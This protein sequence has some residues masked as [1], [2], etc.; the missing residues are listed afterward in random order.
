[1]PNRTAKFVAAIFLLPAAGP[2]ATTSA[3]AD[4]LSE[5]KDQTPAGSHWRYR[6]EHPS[7]R[8]CW[9]LRREGEKPAQLATRPAPAKAEPPMQESVA[10]ARAELTPPTRSV[11]EMDVGAR[12]VVAPGPANVASPAS[13]PFPDPQNVS[14]RP[15]VVASR[16]PDPSAVDTTASPAAA[17]EPPGAAA[18]S[19]TQAVPSPIATTAVPLAVADASLAKQSRSILMLII[20]VVGALSFVGVMGRAM[21]GLGGKR[22]RRKTQDDRRAVRN[23]RRAIWDSIVTDRPQPSPSPIQDSQA[24]D[25]DMPRVPRDDPRAPDDPN[26]RIAEMLARLSRSAAA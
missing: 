18:P 25:L 24:R 1:M 3:A 11:Q 22:R 14:A 16:W 8:H 15:S 9:Y 4:C 6:V 23:E 5:P 20:A 12:P 2:L 7:N 13:N 21:F 17:V 26:R 19:N 10:D